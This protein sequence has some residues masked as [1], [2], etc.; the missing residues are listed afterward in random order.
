M[1]SMRYD[2]TH[3]T[4]YNFLT[5]RLIA[6]GRWTGQVTCGINGRMDGWWNDTIVAQNEIGLVAVGLGHTATATG[7]MY[8]ATAEKRK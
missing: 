8:S 1:R 6:G 4:G 5:S 3:C 7:H 2:T